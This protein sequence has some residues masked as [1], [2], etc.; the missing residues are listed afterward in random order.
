MMKELDLNQD[1]S[2]KHLEQQM[3]T[4]SF[5]LFFCAPVSLVL[6]RRF[7]LVWFGLLPRRSNNDCNLQKAKCIPS[8]GGLGELPSARRI[9]HL[10]V[11][12]FCDSYPA[13]KSSLNRVT[14]ITHYSFINVLDVGKA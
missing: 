14:A 5:T 3:E 4:D 7:G 12:T 9:I 13:G 8:A 11:P 6:S 2:Q 10:N 1:L